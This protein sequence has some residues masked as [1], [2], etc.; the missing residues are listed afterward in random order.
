MEISVRGKQRD[1]P[2]RR[3]LGNRNRSCLRH[4]C[5]KVRTHHHLHLDSFPRTVTEFINAEALNH[6]CP[7]FV[8][9]FHIEGDV[10]HFHLRIGI[11]NELEH[12]L[13]QR[14]HDTEPRRTARGKSVLENEFA[15]G[16][17]RLFLQ[18]NRRTEIQRVI[19]LIEI[20]RVHDKPRSES[21][22][23]WCETAV[24]NDFIVGIAL[25]SI[26]CFNVHIYRNIRRMFSNNAGD[27]RIPVL[28]TGSN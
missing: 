5:F 4:R 1:L 7:P 24:P 18:G 16:E 12:R 17:P 10:L 3:I 22:I 23:K 13:H 26:A 6:R 8:L 19:S 25:L 27:G 2:I 28:H 11:I 21:G 9:Y 20:K 14:L 15:R